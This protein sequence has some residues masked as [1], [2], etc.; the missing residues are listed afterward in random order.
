M[1]Q[2]AGAKLDLNSRTNGDGNLLPWEEK[3]L[4]AVGNVIAFWG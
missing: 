2:T 1:E 3:T 4:I